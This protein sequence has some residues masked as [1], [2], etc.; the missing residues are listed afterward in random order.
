MFDGAKEAKVYNLI[1]DVSEPDSEAMI[2]GANSKV[3][4]CTFNDTVTQVSNR[5]QVLCVVLLGE[6]SEIYNCLLEGAPQTGIKT[7][8]NS[9]VHDNIIKMRVTVT[10]GY[11][12]Q[13]YNDKNVKVHHNKIVPYDGRGIHVRGSGWDVHHNYVEV[14]NGPNTE[15][16]AGR[17]LKMTEHGIKLEKARNAK[18][19]DN[20][21][22]SISVPGG[23]PTPLNLDVLPGSNNQIY[24]NTFVALDRHNDD[25]H[26]AYLMNRT[27]ASITIEDN[28]FYTNKW[29]LYFEWGGTSNNTFRRCTFAKLQPSTGDE[30]AEFGNTWPSVNN[31]FVDCRFLG[32]IDPKINGITAKAYHNWRGDADYSIAWSLDLTAVDGQAKLPGASVT[33]TDQAGMEVA[34][35]KTD[36]DGKFTAELKQYTVK[37]TGASVIATDKAGKE[38][39]KGRRSGKGKLIAYLDEYTLGYADGSVTVTDQHGKEVVNGKIDADGKFTSDLEEYTLKYTAASGT[40]T[41]K[42]DKKTIKGKMDKAEKFTIDTKEYTVNRSGASVILTDKAGKRVAKGKMLKSGRARLRFTAD[43]KTYSVRYRG[44]SVAVIDKDDKGITKGKMDKAGKL[45]IYLTEYAL[46]C[47]DALVTVTNKAGE[48]LA[49]G[50]I[51]AERKFTADLKDYTLNYTKG[52]DTTEVV[53]Y[54]TYTVAVSAG[55]KSGKFEIAPTKPMLGTFDMATG[56]VK[57][58]AQPVIEPEERPIDKYWKERIKLAIEEEN[59]GVK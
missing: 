41:T 13:G 54:G 39:T 17:G 38:V 48:E 5:H 43:K 14:R 59:Q 32:G 44:A 9:E 8:S 33:I 7:K 3:Y 23:F 37:Y 45:V 26:A 16:V 25:A 12:V 10:N 21:V 53:E 1:V 36:A 42:V 57:L 31:M 20:V 28:T 34:K 30:F 24:D 19:H 35:G 49:T 11:G 52:A 18:V 50:D 6:G 27:G 15:Y 22:L 46:K 2:I 29:S 4:N 40:I 51:D 55:E 56:K 58:T 47:S